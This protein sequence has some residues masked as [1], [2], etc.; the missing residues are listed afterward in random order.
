MLLIRG[1]YFYA[2]EMVPGVLI[3]RSIFIKI[4]SGIQKS[5]GAEIHIR[6]T[7]TQTHACTHADSKV[8]S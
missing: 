5:I 8:I 1:I 7:D 4:G 2:V 6:D 3:Y